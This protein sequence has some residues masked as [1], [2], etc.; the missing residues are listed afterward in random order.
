LPDFGFVVLGVVFGH[1]EVALELGGG[2]AL[3]V[4]VETALVGYEGAGLG[5]GFEGEG[6]DDFGDADI[7]VGGVGVEDW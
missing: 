4:D 5:G 7:V 2:G 3:D 1:V 6:V